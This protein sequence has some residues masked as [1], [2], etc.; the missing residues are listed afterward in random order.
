[1]PL[2]IRGMLIAMVALGIDPAALKRETALK[3]LRARAEALKAIGQSRSLRPEQIR[4]AQHVA[5][6]A[7]HQAVARAQQLGV[8]RAAVVEAVGVD[9]LYL[10]RG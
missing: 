3:R 4:S 2:P 5:L 10:P 8:P 1:M 9:P 6:V 7:L